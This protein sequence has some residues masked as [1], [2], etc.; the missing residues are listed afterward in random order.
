M[1]RWP[2]PKVNCALEGDGVRVAGDRWGLTRMQI[3]A[4]FWDCCLA[5][6]WPLAVKNRLERHVLAADQQ[7]LLKPMPVDPAS[8]RRALPQLIRPHS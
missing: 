8:K 3:G 1:P 7:S 6:A 4:S 2:R 5:D